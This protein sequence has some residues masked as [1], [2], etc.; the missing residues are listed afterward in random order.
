MPKSVAIQS[1]CRCGAQVMQRRTGK[2]A[3]ER[4]IDHAD[5]EREHARFVYQ[6]FA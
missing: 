4:R 2:S 5:A 1:V 6:R 3:A